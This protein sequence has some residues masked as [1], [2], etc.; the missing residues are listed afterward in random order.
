MKIAIKNGFLI[1]GTG[2][3]RQVNS[4]ILIEDTK[5]VDIILGKNNSGKEIDITPDTLIIDASGKTILPGLIDAHLHLLGIR[6][7]NPVQWT[8]DT[9]ALK[10]VRA[11]ADV[12]KLIEAGF[13]SVRCA[14]SEVSVYL[15]KA[16]DEG[17][18]QG[19]RIIAAHKVIT[20]TG[21]HGDTHE[22]PLGWVL[23]ANTFWRMADGVDE[24]RRAAREQIREGA[25]V[26]KICT[27]GGVLSEKDSP[28]QAQF[29]DEEITAMT[30]EAHRV[31]IKV[32]AHAQSPEGIQNA[33]RNGVDTIEHGIYLDDETIQ[34]MLA[35]NTIVVPTFAIVNAL[36]TKGREAAVP[37]YGL[38]KAK[39]AHKE[40][41]KSITLAHKAGVKIALGTDFC[42][43]DIIPH[44][45]NAV[46]LEIFVNQIGMTPMEAIKSATKIGAEALG[47]EKSIGTL[48]KGK[49]ADLLIIDGN[50]LEDI[51]TLQNK[52]DILVVMKN[53]Q[54]IVDRR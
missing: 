26:I 52:D 21:G 3:E 27:T 41:I 1:D 49:I 4:I 17:T 34:M 32:M 20:Q 7:M 35:S 33:I 23:R 24:C 46:E 36:V 48:E 13:T 47:I 29:V 22:L 44:G 50:P 12:K 45:E 39:T 14:G 54:I 6:S 8:L 40:H 31:G 18:I 43:P 42:G 11:V 5:I 9:S 15:K 30:T 53:G 19:P 25:G 16:I 51:A 10:A 28:T 38:I 37:E 2:A